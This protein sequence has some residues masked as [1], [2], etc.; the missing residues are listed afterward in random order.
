LPIRESLNEEGRST[1]GSVRQ[2][3]V[4]S[5]LVVAEVALALVLLVGAGLL[6]RSFQSLTR[7]QPGFDPANL[8]VVNLP[9]SPQKYA[10]G[11]KMVHAV[12]RIVERV[13][14]IPGV[15]SAAMTTGLP[16]AGAGAMIHFNRTST[17]PAGPDDYVMAGFRAVTPGYLGTLGVSLQRGR[18]LTPWDRQGAAPVVVINETMAREFF[19]DRDPIGER[20]QLGT[21]P[22]PDFPTMEIVGIVGDVKQSFATGSKA[23]MFVPY[24]QFPDPMLGGMYRNTALVV[25][26]PEDPNEV[27]PF[28]RSALR[29]IDPG[30]P[31]VN[32][33]TMN[34]AIAGT[35]AQ[36]RFQMT[37]LL[38][39]A[40]VAVALAV[41]GVYGVMAY[42]VTQRIPEI[43]V[44]IAVG[45]SPGQVV[46]MVV[47][48]G[49]K[50]A[51]IGVAIGLA[52]AVI[53]APALRSLL[54]EITAFDPLT[55]GGAAAVLGVAALLASYI[56]ARRAASVSPTAAL[57]S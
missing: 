15:E 5:A 37:L 42:T 3:K 26:T 6:L 52:A 8:L 44:R 22:D 35:V 39:F 10:D 56:P 17:P 55:F 29:E 48:D 18:M 9:L 4:R 40:S 33:R 23:E 49:A 28:V 45:A 11:G 27:A 57:R 24:A 38:I 50:L 32:V 7:V 1:S 2:R 19:P 30:Q 53:V 16:M 25:R 41:I 36:P 46:W 47:K 43:G 12:E 20:I 21:E 51:L 34:A 14:T 31:L 13:R 54:F